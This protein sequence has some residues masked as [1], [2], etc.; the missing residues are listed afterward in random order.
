M[1]SIKKISIAFLLLVTVIACKDTKNAEDTE[2]KATIEKIET[3]ETELET[4]TEELEK[5]ASELDESLNALD[6]I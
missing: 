4:A 3:L 5:K 1:K 6:T 2:A